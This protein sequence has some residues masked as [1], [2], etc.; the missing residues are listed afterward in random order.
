VILLMI[1]YVGQIAFIPLDAFRFHL[2]PK[3]GALISFVGL[4]LCGGLVDSNSCHEDQ[5]L[6]RRW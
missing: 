6:R 4:A 5:S 2:M 1:S 3:P